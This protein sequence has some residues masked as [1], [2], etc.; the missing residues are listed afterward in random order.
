A[1]PAARC[2]NFLRGSLMMRSRA[3]VQAEIT[4]ALHVARYPDRAGVCY[5][6]GGGAGGRGAHLDGEK[7]RRKDAR[8][9]TSRSRSVA[10]PPL[11]PFT[12]ETAAQKARLAEDAWNTREPARVALAYTVDSIWRNRAE[13]IHG[14]A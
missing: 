14:R 2:R 9:S 4:R 5:L 10:R 3:I 11:P 12:A 6:L 13:F 7:A 1:T 8:T